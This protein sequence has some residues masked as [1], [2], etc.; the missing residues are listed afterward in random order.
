[1]KCPSG[2][3][4]T[5]ASV[6]DR[7]RPGTTR[8]EVSEGSHGIHQ[9]CVL[10]AAE[11]TRGYDRSAGIPSKERGP[12]VVAVEPGLQGSARASEKMRKGLAVPAVAQRPIRTSR[13]IDM[14]LDG[15][16]PTLQGMAHG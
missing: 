13:I 9:L 2:L 1:V 16:A 4:S 7:S 12:F 6:D 8:D 14:A 5:Q 11:Y 3:D 10:F 15:A